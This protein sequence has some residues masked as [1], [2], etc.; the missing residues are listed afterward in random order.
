MPEL[1]YNGKVT[2]IKSTKPRRNNLPTDRRVRDVANLAFP[3][4]DP[5]DYEEDVQ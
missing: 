1:F 3:G 5:E 2:Y 4:L